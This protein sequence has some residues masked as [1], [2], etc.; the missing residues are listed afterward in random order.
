MKTKIE[1]A[2]N[3]LDEINHE[4][5]ITEIRTI[6]KNLDQLLIQMR[7]NELETEIADLADD[8]KL[9]RNCLKTN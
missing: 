4:N 2:I 5:D 1:I 3:L 6:L 9:L 8:L 7:I